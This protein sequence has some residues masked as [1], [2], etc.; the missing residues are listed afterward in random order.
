MRYGGVRTSL[1][2]RGRPIGPLD[3]LIG[4]HAQL[5]DVILVTHNTKEIEGLRLGNWMES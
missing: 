5:L 3:T 2:R 1:E 4:S